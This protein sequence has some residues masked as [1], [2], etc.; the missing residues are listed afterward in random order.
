MQTA[1]PHFDVGV[2]I[3]RFQVHSLHDG[4]ADLIQHVCDEHEKTLV[5]LGVSPLSNST[6]N[7]LDIE[8]RKQML[9]ELFPQLTILYVK[10]VGEDDVWSRKVDELVGDFLTP[11]Q[12]AVIY[13]SRDSFIP[14]YTGKFKTR[15][16]LSD[17]VYSGTAVRKQIARSSTRATPDF[18]AGAIW[19]SQ[20][21]FPTAYTT[22]D[23]APM[24]ENGQV[25]L[26]R[27]PGEK[28]YR[29]IGGFSDPR[30]PSFEADARR[31]TMEEANIDIGDVT[32]I[33][34]MTIDD[35]RYRSE[36]DC[37]KTMMFKAKYVM[38]RPTPGDD[39]EEVRWFE[40][41]DSFVGV[42][43]AHVDRLAAQIMPL[44]RPLLTMLV[45]N[46]EV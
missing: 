18:R 36:P 7:P 34:S 38:G 15:E 24:N 39:I 25:L 29:F 3:G 43:A 21:R 6:S 42:G 35:W 37:I 17:R 11:G 27:K 23:I 30:S 13:G 20:S 12:S 28:L 5:I 8:S 10:D 45:K 2:I 16:L 41:P 26:G 9:L 1:L 44:H 22:V 19:A 14:H 4:H 40:L 32:Y 46:L 31:E 33:G